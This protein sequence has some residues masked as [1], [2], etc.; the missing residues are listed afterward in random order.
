MA[1]CT[2]IVRHIDDLGRLVIPKEIRQTMKIKEGDAFIISTTKSGVLFEKYNVNANI[3][4]DL[5]TIVDNY[6][7]E[8]TESEIKGIREIIKSIY[9]RSVEN[10]E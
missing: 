7:E 6:G 3:T 1:K 8:M 2:G 4:D 5:K 9:L 10:E